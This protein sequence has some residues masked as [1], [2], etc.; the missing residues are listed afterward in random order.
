MKLSFN[1]N[2]RL[3]TSSFLCCTN[4]LGTLAITILILKES[5]QICHPTPYYVSC[6]LWEFSALTCFYRFLQHP[7]L[8]LIVEGSVCKKPS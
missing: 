5:T 6:F 4:V 8:E 3:L 7:V 1:I 2:N